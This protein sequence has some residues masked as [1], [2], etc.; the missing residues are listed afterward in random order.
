M[1]KKTLNDYPKVGSF[2][3]PHCG[4]KNEVAAIDVCYGGATIAIGANGWTAA[5][6]DFEVFGHSPAEITIRNGRRA[7]ARA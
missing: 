1:T 6:I 2:A 5:A 3:C 4:C 7:K